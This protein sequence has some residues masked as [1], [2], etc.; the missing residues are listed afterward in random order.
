[1]HFADIDK[2]NALTPQMRACIHLFGHAANGLDMI[3][4]ASFEGMFPESFADVKSPLQ[5]RIPN[6][7]TYKL[8]RREVLQIL[9]QN[10]YRE[11]PWEKLRILIRA[12]GL[13]EKLEHN[14]SRLKKHAI[15]AG[16][17]PAD[18]TAEWVWSLDAESAAGSHRGFLRLGVVAF[19]ALF[20]IPAVVD[21][22]LLPPKRI[23]FPPVYLSSGELKA[24]L[25]P[26]LAQITKD[27]TTSHRS[28]L[29]TIWRAIIASDLQF[30]EDPSPEELL[31][32]QAEIAQLPRESVSVSETSWIIYQRNFR[33]ALRKAVRQYGMESVV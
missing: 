27:A 21:S 22:G 23:G 24:T 31:A 8:A 11:D 6:A 3:P 14:W 7:R 12:A 2:T 15:A 17:T 1:M 10:G 28:A 20:D 18:V 13:K 19:D 9:V 16:L 4:L 32:A 33:A 29:N 25:P 30:S 5:K 26:Q